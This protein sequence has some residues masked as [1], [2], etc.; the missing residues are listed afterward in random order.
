M[1]AGAFRPKIVL[2][3]STITIVNPLRTTTFPLDHIEPSHP[4]DTRASGSWPERRSNSDSWGLGSAERDIAVW[5]GARTRAD[6]VCA[7]IAEAV[8]APRA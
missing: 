4:L 7:A 5:V 1:Y 2:T 6:E 3:R 8:R